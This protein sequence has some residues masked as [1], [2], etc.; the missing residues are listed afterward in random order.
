MLCNTAYGGLQTIWIDLKQVH[1]CLQQ[2]EHLSCWYINVISGC[3]WSEWTEPRGTSIASGL[4]TKLRGLLLRKWLTHRIE[5]NNAFEYSSVKNNWHSQYNN[6]RL[7]RSCNY[8]NW[9]FK[10]KDWS[11]VTNW[12]RRTFSNID[13]CRWTV[14]SFIVI[15][16]HRA[17]TISIFIM[18]SYHDIPSIRVGAHLFSFI[19]ET[20]SSVDAN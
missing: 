16:N 20:I 4:E 7:I 9:L 19:I 18:Q 14:L 5:K 15:D 8:L 10:L 6:E 12:K 13:G 1:S 11:R 17:K 2:Q 3:E